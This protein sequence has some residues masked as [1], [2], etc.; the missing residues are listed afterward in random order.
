M[1][2]PRYFVVVFG[3]PDPNGDPVD[4][5]M[6]MAGDG[7]PPFPVDPGDLL[8]L[9]CTDEYPGFSKQVPGIGVALRTDVTSIEYRWLPLITPI[10]R[11]DL[12]KTFTQHDYQKMGQLGIK[13]HRA[14][15]ISKQSFDTTVAGRSFAWA[16][17]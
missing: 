11:D 12:A 6:Y 17:I 2:S 1:N 9:Y 16:R 10:S 5:G 13:A 7:Y 4:S 3:N 15:E 8:I 14:F